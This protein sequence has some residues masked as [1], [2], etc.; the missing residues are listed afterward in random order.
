MPLLRLQTMR[1]ATIEDQWIKFFYSIHYHWQMIPT[2]S[3][4]QVV[5]KSRG[6]PNAAYIHVGPNMD[7]VYLHC[8]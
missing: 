4:L 7:W 5:T 1:T 8:Y 3:A 6:T 2:L